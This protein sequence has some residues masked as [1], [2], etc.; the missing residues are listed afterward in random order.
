MTNSAAC[1]PTIRTSA[2]PSIR[3]R[4]ASGVLAVGLL[5]AGCS[6]DASQRSVDRSTSSTD[7]VTST[8]TAARAEVDVLEADDPGF[9]KVPD[10]LPTGRH[11]DLVRIQPVAGAP[12]G[13]TWQRIMY[14]SETPAGEP[15]VV[16]GVITLPQGAP[17]NGGWPLFAHAHGSTGIA[18]DCA[19]SVSLGGDGTEAVEIKLL[20]IWV[21]QRR[22]AVVS[23]DYEGL[24]GPGR[25]PML[26]GVS[27]GRSVLDSIEAARQ[28]PGA[29]FEDR[30][31]VI[32]YSQG[33]H[34]AAWAN[35]IAPEWAPDLDIVGVLAGAP[36]TELFDL[37]DQGDAAALSF[38]SALTAA[39]P[40]LDPSTALTSAGLEALAALD[41][42]C[43]APLEQAGPLTKVDVRTTEPWVSAIRA[44]EPGSSPGVAPVLIVHSKEDERVPVAGSEAF[45]SRVCKA[46]GI[47]ERRV[48][49]E[50]THVGAA[51]PAYRQG[52]DWILGLEAGA[53]PVSTCP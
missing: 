8:T 28:V 42:S 52:I 40:D 29:V 14:L 41:R 32:G 2:S 4:L 37:F 18:D 35:Q 25:H 44:N 12:A 23:T 6:D 36:A 13:T 43:D 51:I 17:P 49:D 46:G 15:T 34:A 11:G 21:P 50:G 1:C 10:P 48:L 7:G 39:D 30:V 47:V 3:W 27:E 33:G 45:Q 9:Y 38:V 31:G 19:P 53:Q 5:L 22:I 24:G 16:T 20:S 26:V